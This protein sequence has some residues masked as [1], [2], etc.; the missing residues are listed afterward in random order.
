MGIYLGPDR[1]RWVPE[2][3]NDLVEAAAGGVLDETHWVELKVA[4]P[5]KNRETNLELARDLA[6][7]A[8][9][10]GLLVIGIRDER[11]RAGDVVGTPLQGLIDR[12]DQVSRDNIHPPLVVRPIAVP[13]PARPGEG[14]L[15]VVVDASSEA[16]HMADHHYWGRGATGKR[17]LTDIEVRNT[18]ALNSRR[19][20]DTQAE[21]D[22]L[23]DSNPLNSSGCI[24][25][26]AAPRS[27]SRGALADSIDDLT[28]LYAQMTKAMTAQQDP[29]GWWVTDLRPRRTLDGVDICNGEVEQF[30]EHP[31]EDTGLNIRLLRIADTGRVALTM[32]GLSAA[33]GDRDPQRQLWI[34]GA[35]VLTEASLRLAGQLADA[36]G[37]AGV[38][39]V[40]VA[41]T[42][43]RGAR[44]AR[45]S[46]VGSGSWLRYP[47]ERYTRLAQ[48]T[49]ARLVE[50][51][52]DVVDELL[53][54]LRRVLT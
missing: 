39:D 11:G 2:T 52:T 24:Y 12:I 6:S 42:D 54:P 21:L 22:Q 3:W 14:C 27:A 48:A 46:A 50:H 33:T 37:Y 41:L 13:D 38:W 40:G 47:E 9:S 51:L 10:G 23:V 29:H 26:L 35:Q 8:V 53:G 19:H 36:S 43:L 7:L 45:R 30:A 31:A 4:L 34:E 17:V 25:V 49:S 44:A 15:L 18:I 20:T 16:P 32:N 5:P 1:P 28:W